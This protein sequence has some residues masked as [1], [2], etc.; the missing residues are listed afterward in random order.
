[1]LAIQRLV[2]P[3]LTGSSDNSHAPDGCGGIEGAAPVQSHAMH[4]C[5]WRPTPWQPC[6]LFCC[7]VLGPEL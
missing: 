1:M 6:T 3:L 4:A 7:S 2:A 5:A